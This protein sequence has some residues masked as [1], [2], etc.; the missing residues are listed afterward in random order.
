MPDEV[1]PIEFHI[2][3]YDRAIANLQSRIYDHLRRNVP[4]FD[5]DEPQMTT[6]GG[7]IRNVGGQNPL[8]QEFRPITATTSISVDTIRQTDITSYMDSLTTQ[9]QAL[10][11]EEEGIM[12]ASLLEVLNHPKA[13]ATQTDEIVSW[14]FVLNELEQRDIGFDENGAPIITHGHHNGSKEQ[15]THLQHT[16]TPDIRHRFIQILDMKRR[17]TNATPRRR[18]LS[19]GDS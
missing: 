19:W 15:R 6:H 9:M 3:A 18:G 7:R 11:D 8:D 4:F 14:D 2:P 12:V 5:D 1:L 17:A 10:L 16:M 13:P